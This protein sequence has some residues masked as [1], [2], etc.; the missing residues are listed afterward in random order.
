M[1]FILKFL[2]K[3]KQAIKEYPTQT[4]Y[5]DDRAVGTY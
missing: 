4:L 5:L 2:L 1:F 3:N